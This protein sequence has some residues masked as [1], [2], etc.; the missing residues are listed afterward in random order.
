M[1]T[2]PEFLALIASPLNWFIVG[3]AGAGDDVAEVYTSIVL[4]YVL[5]NLC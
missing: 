5:Y 4:R 3:R 1:L 2:E